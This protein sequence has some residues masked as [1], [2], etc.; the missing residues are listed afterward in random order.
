M[1]EKTYKTI[2]FASFKIQVSNNSLAVDS[3]VF[4]IESDRILFTIPD[5]LQEDLKILKMTIADL[6]KSQII[7]P[8][9]HIDS[10]N[11]LG[12]A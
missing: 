5:K 4:A 10:L 12:V 6:S 11:V 1:H 2:I 8:A 9:V 3:M 7:N